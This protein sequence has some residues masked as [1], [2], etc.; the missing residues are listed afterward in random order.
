[1][2]DFSPA[3][4]EF[5]E[6][7]QRIRAGRQA[8]EQAMCNAL[9][10][11]LDVGEA[12]IE[13]RTRV[14]VGQWGRWLSANCSLSVRS[15]KLYVQLA[16]HRAEIED[17]MQQVPELSLRGARRVISKPTETVSNPKKSDLI[18]TLDK[19]TDA[20]LTEALAAL[21]FDRFLQVMP[22]EWRPRLEARAGG[23]MISR[24]KVRH[25]NVRLKNL[26][27]AKLRLVGGTEASPTPH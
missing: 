22:A 16:R 13:A 20:E 11:A 10:V 26:D 18:A 3:R 2:S 1:M 5:A 19:A 7:A 17:A 9:H 6:L 23:Q 4:Q 14:S 21:G 24:A 25:P 8:I 27:K 15:A 12:L